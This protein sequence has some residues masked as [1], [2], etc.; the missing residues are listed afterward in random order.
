MCRA[1]K[2]ACNIDGVR[3]STIFPEKLSRVGPMWET[4]TSDDMCQVGDDFV[5]DGSVRPDSPLVFDHLDKV[6]FSVPFIYFAV[7]G[8]YF[9]VYFIKHYSFWLK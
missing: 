2:H 3:C 6:L 9:I 4:N 7:L 5:V 1:S 8:L